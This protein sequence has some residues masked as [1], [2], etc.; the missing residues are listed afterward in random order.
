MTKI[1]LEPIQPKSKVLIDVTKLDH[2]LKGALDHT[3]NIV[4]DDFHKTVKT[5]RKP[6]KFEKKK[7]RTTR[8]GL[9]ATVSTNDEIY[10]YID[11][12]TKPHIIRPRRVNYLRF[13][14]G[15][16]AKTRVG[17]IS[18]RPGGPSGPTV[19]AK[20]VLHPGFPARKF[21]KTIAERRQ[22]NLV[23]L[24]R[25]AFNRSLRFGGMR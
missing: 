5:W 24:V 13:Q 2:E 18:S 7:P 21:A 22:K 16:R 14:T 15:Y 8:A 4:R 17:I 12:G 19:L 9:E 1:R 11:E 3:A 10:F 20:Q 6:A 25:L 23:N